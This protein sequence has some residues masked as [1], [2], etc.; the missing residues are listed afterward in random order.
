MSD[1]INLVTITLNDDDI[2]VGINGDPAIITVVDSFQKSKTEHGVRVEAAADLALTS[3]CFPVR[4]QSNWVPPASSAGQTTVLGTMMYNP[5][6][7][8]RMRIA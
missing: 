8:G 3:I 4:L 2:N 6:K 7:I 5:N 1:D